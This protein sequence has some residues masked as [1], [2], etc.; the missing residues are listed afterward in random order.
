MSEIIEII[1]G[2]VINPDDNTDSL[3]NISLENGIIKRIY[4]KEEGK[5]F[6]NSKKIDA[7][8]LWILPGLIDIYCHLREPGEEYKE[9]IESGLKSATKGGFTTIMCTPDTKP[10]NDTISVT[11][12]I[13][14][15]ASELN[16][17]NLIP[18]CALSKGLKGEEIGE[19][20]EFKEAKIKA[21]SN[22]DTPIP[23]SLF[24]RRAFEYARTF[25]LPVISFPE[26]GTLSENGCCHEGFVSTKLGLRGIPVEAEEI[27]VGRDI[28]ISKISDAQLHLVKVSCE[29]SLRI[30]EKAKDKGLK[31]SSSLTPHHLILS[32]ESI[33]S[34]DVNTKVKPPLRSIEHI[35]SLRDG[36]KKGI[37]DIITTDHCPQSPVEKEL[38]FDYAEYGMI[39]FE[40]AVPLVLEL[41]RQGVIS[42]LKMASLLSYNPAK[43]FDIDG[44][45]LKV[46]CPAD[47]TIIDPEKEFLLTKDEI[48]SKS[49]NT[50]FLN[51]KLKGKAVLTM[52]KG[53]ILYNEL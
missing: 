26:D 24:M 9:D 44:G 50:P 48:V 47:I 20:G 17:A 19:F 3:K 32:D 1:N 5:P 29:G 28:A 22:A 7:K 30:I 11:N 37:I 18:I 45:K 36:I 40:T 43:I 31:I 34:F 35:E 8:G 10:P 38:E 46:G 49:K 25:N 52:V 16:L 53:R 42:P 15:K 4:K 13:L 2:R 23:S 51:K 41:V 21:L 27:M 6:E 14:K 39:G 12:F 33:L